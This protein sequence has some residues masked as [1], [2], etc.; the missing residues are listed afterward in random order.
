MKL[1]GWVKEEHLDVPTGEGSTGFLNFAQQGS[2]VGV[3]GQMR[4]LLLSEWSNSRA[5]EDESLQ[6]PKG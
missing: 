4:L 3:P 5:S 1:I 2:M 6:S